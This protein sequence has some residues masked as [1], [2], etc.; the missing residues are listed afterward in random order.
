MMRFVLPLL[1]G[2]SIAFA[3][4]AYPDRPGKQIV[5]KV[6]GGCHGLRLMENMRKTPAAWK[7]SIDDMVTRGMKASDEDIETVTAY[8]VKYLTRLNINQ[9][10]PA[11]IA[12][13][14]D[15]SAREAEAIAA[16]RKANG[17]IKNFD[18]LETIPGL[19]AKKLNEQR[20]RIAFST[21]A[22]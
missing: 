19:D 7:T 14:L 21:A 3:G 15:L 2:A 1:A 18:E 12:D 4:P 10:T 6:C 5:E 9:A 22:F 20:N 8:F 16:Y 13:V 17:K 11:A